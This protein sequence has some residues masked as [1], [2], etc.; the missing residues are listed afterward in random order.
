[1]GPVPDRPSP[2]KGLAFD[3]GAN[4]VAV[5]VEIADA[6][7]ALDVTRVVSMRLWSLA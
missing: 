4:L 2:A 3:D 7:V 5:D 6:G 1:L